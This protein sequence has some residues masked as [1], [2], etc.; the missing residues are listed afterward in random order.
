MRRTVAQHHSGTA[1]P[2]SG[3]RMQ[4]DFHQLSNAGHAITPIVHI[5]L[6]QPTLWR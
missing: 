6:S 5:A 2:K 4:E 3:D 1:L